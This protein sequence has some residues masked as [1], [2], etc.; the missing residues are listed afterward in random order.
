MKQ[1]KI[2]GVAN[3]CSSTSSGGSKKSTL[4]RNLGKNDVVF[5]TKGNGRNEVFLQLLEEHAA[6][7]VKSSKFDKMGLIQELI[8]DWKG[9]FYFLNPKTNELGLARENSSSSNN[10]N[11]KRGS[12]TVE[13]S[14]PS[15]SSKLYTSVRRMMNYVVAKNNYQYVQQSSS[16]TIRVNSQVTAQEKQRKRSTSLQPVKSKKKRKQAPSS[17]SDTPKKSKKTKT[18]T[19]KQPVTT[20]VPPVASVSLESTR[21]ESLSP[22][23]MTSSSSSAIKEL[24]AP[25]LVTPEPSPRTFQQVRADENVGIHAVFPTNH[26]LVT[27]SAIELPSTFASKPPSISRGNLVRPASTPWSVAYRKPTVSLPST[28]VMDRQYVH[29][30]EDRAIHTLVSLS[31]ASWTEDNDDNDEPEYGLFY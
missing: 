11:N 8:R 25:L 23:P 19:K 3:N 20:D 2:V 21:F 4:L 9:N 14:N 15:T 12:D 10:N 31:T 22:I 6:L 5:G 17:S 16:P 26:T 27:P 13:T 7:Y 1:T 29:S 24:R 30:L 18:F 28:Q